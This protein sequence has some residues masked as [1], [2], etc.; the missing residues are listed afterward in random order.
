MEWCG[1]CFVY[2]GQGTQLLDQG[3]LEVVA[4]VGVKLP[5]QAKAR[6]ETIVG[7]CQVEAS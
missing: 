5:R 7:S 6:K 2:S 4:L 1:A 3:G